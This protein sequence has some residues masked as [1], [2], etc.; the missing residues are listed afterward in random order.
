MIFLFDFDILCFTLSKQMHLAIQLQAIQALNKGLN[1]WMFRW[2]IQNKYS[3]WGL[4]IHTNRERL[5]T[6]NR[7]LSIPVLTDFQDFN[8]TDTDF[9]FRKNKITIPI[10]IFPKIPINRYRHRLLV[11]PYIR[12]TLLF[13]AL[14][15][16]AST[17]TFLVL[18]GPFWSYRIKNSL[19]LKILTIFDIKVLWVI[20]TF[21]V[22]Y[23]YGKYK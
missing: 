22:I 4:H 1:I 5:I 16:Q 20:L 19:S 6:L 23:L 9:L 15:T 21:K 3:F 14:W 10:P 2:C 13:L 12:I 17:P 11:Y 7:F 18:L 8:L